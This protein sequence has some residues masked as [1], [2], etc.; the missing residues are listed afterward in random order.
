MKTAKG[1]ELVL[2]IFTF[3][4]FAGCNSTVPAADPPVTPSPTAVETPTKPEIAIGYD[5]RGNW[6]YEDQRIV[7]MEQGELAGDHLAV[8]HS[9]LIADGKISNRL[10]DQC[11]RIAAKGLV[12]QKRRQADEKRKDEAYDKAHPKTK[13]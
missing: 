6:S 12:L 7:A 9:S 13:Q 2:S 1:S 11:D 8:C 3:F 10:A 4:M 5:W